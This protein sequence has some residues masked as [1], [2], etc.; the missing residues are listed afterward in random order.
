MPKPWIR[1]PEDRDVLSDW[2]FRPGDL[3]E[4]RMWSDSGDPQ[5]SCLFELLEEG[6]RATSGYLLRLRYIAASDQY[7]QWWFTE[8]EGADLRDK[9]TLHLCGR[10]YDDCP[11]EEDDEEDEC[12]IGHSDQFRPVSL[13]DVTEKKIQWLND[14][15]NSDLKR[16]KKAQGKGPAPSKASALRDEDEDYDEGLDDADEDAEE[17]EDSEEAQMKKELERIKKE[18]AKKQQARSSKSKGSKLTGKKKEKSDSKSEGL[19]SLGGSQEDEDEEERPKRGTKRK[20]QEDEDEAPATPKKRKEKKKRRAMSPFTGKGRRREPSDDDENSDESSFHHALTL[21]SGPSNGQLVE[22]SQRYPGVLAAR[23]LTKM[24]GLV[25]R[26]GGASEVLVSSDLITPPAAVPYLLTCLLPNHAGTGKLHIRSLREIRTLCVVLDLLAKKEG[27]RA[28]DV[29][30]QR[31]KALEM[32]LSED[33]W[34]RAQHLELI[35]LEGSTLAE[36]DERMMTAKE[37]ELEMKIR[38]RSDQPQGWTREGAWNLGKGRGNG[39]WQPGGKR[40]PKGGKYKSKDKA[41]K[42]AGRGAPAPGGGGAAAGE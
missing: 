39:Q 15:H 18:L 17:K 13:G 40:G 34:K 11:Y 7:L 3:L 19:F 36:Q 42:G 14:D 37:V 10:G 31:L 32:A 26:E 22:F 12:F 41:K 35:P 4:V 24:Q 38:N 8:G 6:L 2:R 16:W 9:G 23:L 25:C 5:G 20:L 29:L 28:A 27:A 30:A 33:D 1:L 21:P